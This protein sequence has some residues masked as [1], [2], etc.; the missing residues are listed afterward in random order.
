MTSGKSLS[1]FVLQGKCKGHSTEST[2]TALII[3]I[4]YKSLTYL[5]YRQIKRKQRNG[6]GSSS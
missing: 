3:H 5:T 6:I 4:N 1:L 2:D